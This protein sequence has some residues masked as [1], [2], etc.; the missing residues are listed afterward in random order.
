[1][2]R[3]FASLAGFL[4]ASLVVG[5]VAAGQ[6]I[7]AEVKPTGV[8]KRITIRSDL[9]PKEVHANPGDT[10]I[11]SNASSTPVLV[12]LDGFSFDKEKSVRL[13]PGGSVSMFF[14]QPG[15]YQFSVHQATG[16]GA[17]SAPPMTGK[18]VISG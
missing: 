11:W 18:I 16:P 10:I 3:T 2:S 6:G 5:A 8:A 17:A 4:V 1:M 15:T 7:A 9:N 13:E 12:S 14:S